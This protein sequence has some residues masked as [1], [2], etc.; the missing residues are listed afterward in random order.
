[1]DVVQGRCV[2]AAAEDAVV[3]LLRGAERDAAFREDGFELLF[4]FFA[5]ERAED[6]FVGR[7]GYFVGVAE[8]SDFV[9]GFGD[10]AC[11]D[12]FPQ[13]LLVFWTWWWCRDGI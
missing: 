7:G 4:G 8:E 9:G 3:G 5:F 10:A 11:L 12:C 6:G 2:G 1:M 13:G